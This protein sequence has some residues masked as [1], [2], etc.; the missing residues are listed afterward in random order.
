MYRL[1]TF[2][3]FFNEVDSLD[4]NTSASFVEGGHRAILATP[5]A[6]MS[7]PS[8]IP[9]HQLMASQQAAFHQ[10]GVSA[11]YETKHQS[12]FEEQRAR[13]RGPPSTYGIT[14]SG[15][16]TPHAEGGEDMQVDSGEAAPRT[17]APATGSAQTQ[18][19]LQPFEVDQNT[20]IELTA[21]QQ[22]VNIQDK[23]QMDQW[24]QAPITTR[25]QV[26][27]TVRAYHTGVIRT[28]MQQLV[29]QVESVVKGL[30][31][32]ILRQRDHLRWLTSESR[33]DQKRICGLQVLLNGFDNKMN[34]EE[35]LYMICWM[36]EQV[37]FFRSYLKL[38]AYDTEGV[39][40][41]YV[42]LNILQCDPATPPSGDGYS[43]ITIVTFKSW[44]LRSQFMQMFGGPTGTPLWK[45]N[46]TS[47]KG[48]FIRATPCSPMFQRKMEVP[49]RV[50]LS[51]INES[52][53]LEHSQVVVLWKTLTIM[54]PQ[55]AREF[56]PQAT[57]LARMHYFEEEGQLKG[58]LEVVPELTKALLTTPPPGALEENCWEHHWSKIVYGIQHEIDQ[59]D[60]DQF[61][62]AQELSKG[63][64]KGVLLGKG[65]RHW[66]ASAVYSS[67]DNPYPI[68]IAVKE[69]SSVVYVWD[70]YCDKFA[71]ADHKV[72]SYTH[73]TF[74]GPP[75]VSKAAPSATPPAAKATAGDAAPA[76]P[77][78]KGRGRGAGSKGS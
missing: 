47:V 13:K 34:P 12:W 59:A 41:N 26:L 56:D 15:L 68:D 2:A 28:E 22:G 20:S 75:A 11:L 31:D 55:A 53:V 30:N 23:A 32:R 52:E 50:L 24:L 36:F 62:H 57:A 51:L 7:A 3:L 58:F 40:A 72:G 35:R 42:F 8:E 19:L 39:N 4:R 38:R 76:T 61:Q 37:E 1:I 45:D 77:K 66:S 9:S 73:S 69:V 14:S 64:G 6:V 63:T 25:Q 17:E 27:E 21:I 78:T 33:A 43:S 18:P 44:D 29:M 67:A 5:P 54:K 10:A 74:A 16:T 70:E 71:M 49:I 48:R 46:Q 60:K 65:K